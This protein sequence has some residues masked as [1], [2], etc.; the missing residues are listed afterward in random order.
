M[1]KY[2][3]LGIALIDACVIIYSW[4]FSKH[5]SINMPEAARAQ[6]IHDDWAKDFEKRYGEK[7]EGDGIKI[8]KQNRGQKS[9][10]ILFGLAFMH[11]IALF[12]IAS[13][14]RSLEEKMPWLFLVTIG[15]IILL[16]NGLIIVADKKWSTIGIVSIIL[17]I[18]IPIRMGFDWLLIYNWKILLGVIVVILFWSLP[19]IL[20]QK[21]QKF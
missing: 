5:K 6:L 4:F 2:V 20:L 7:P 17:I 8:A 11:V 18:S 9:S 14:E 19:T 12:P 16:L 15:G 21:K 1:E 10:M 3:I 13:L